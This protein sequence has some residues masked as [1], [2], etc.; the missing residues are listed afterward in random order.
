ML[1]SRTAHQQAAF[2]SYCFPSLWQESEHN[3][4][5]QTGCCLPWTHSTMDILDRS[6]N[7]LSTIEHKKF[8]MFKPF[9]IYE[10]WNT[11]VVLFIL[12]SALPWSHGNGAVLYKYCQN[13][14]NIIYKLNLFQIKLQLNKD[15]KIWNKRKMMK[16]QLFMK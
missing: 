6:T 3:Q 12:F 5:Q 1:G 8:D 15:I 7:T 14:I 4:V 11:Q 10:K 2:L 9:K 16:Y 13:P